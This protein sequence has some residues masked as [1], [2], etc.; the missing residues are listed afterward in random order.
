MRFLVFM[1]PK[2][3]QPKNGKKPDPHFTPDAKMMAKMGEFNEELNG[4]TRFLQKNAGIAGGWTELEQFFHSDAS[5]G[6]PEEIETFLLSLQASIEANPDAKATLLQLAQGYAHLAEL[7]EKGFTK[8]IVVP[9]PGKTPR[10]ED[11][12]EA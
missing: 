10:P 4:G 6:T 1:I 11:S 7:H 9:P 12:S 2:V 3:Y 5:H 8:P